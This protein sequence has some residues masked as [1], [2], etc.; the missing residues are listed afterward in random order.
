M[1]AIKRLKT[2]RYPAVIALLALIPFIGVL[3]DHQIFVAGDI[4]GSDF[5]NFVYPVK[6]FLGQNLR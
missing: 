1:R 2:I 3:F 4:G 6:H 5:T